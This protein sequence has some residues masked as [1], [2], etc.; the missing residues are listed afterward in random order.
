MANWSVSTFHD[1]RAIPAASIASCKCLALQSLPIWV[2]DDKA[3]S[4]AL[5][6]HFG[7]Q[8]TASSHA[9][10]AL[11]VDRRAGPVQNLIVR[12]ARYSSAK[13]A[14]LRRALRLIATL[15]CSRRLDDRS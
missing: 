12:L 11:P 1:H 2:S 3:H 13:L 9:F 4:L 8:P 6:L 15:T 10:L 7:R 14:L 5:R